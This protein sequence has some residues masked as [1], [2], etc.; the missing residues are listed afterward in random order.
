MNK[1][2]NYVMNTEFNNIK[3]M[4]NLNYILFNEK[5]L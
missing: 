5:T 4:E 3:V 2:K 1:L